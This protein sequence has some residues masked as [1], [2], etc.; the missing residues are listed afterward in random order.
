MH[1]KEN[2]KG[3]LSCKHVVVQTTFLPLINSDSKKV[4][5]EA[6]PLAA[7]SNSAEKLFR[8]TE[9]NFLAL[10]EGS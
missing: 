6:R 2:R 8:V 5:L 3:T 7:I 4:F 1:E 10:K 9:N